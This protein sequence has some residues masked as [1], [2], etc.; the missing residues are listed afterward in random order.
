MW[1]LK[2]KLRHKDCTLAPLVEKYNVQIEFSPL[3]HYLEGKYV[4]TLAIHT[5]RGTD[6]AVKG[7]IK[8]LRKHPKI[9]RIEVSKAIFTLMKEKAS[10]GTYQTIYNPKLLY[11]T[12]G[13][14]SED[15][16]ET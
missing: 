6:K 16:Y 4:Y 1:Y 2:F 9:V 11:V 7:Y 14:N 8:E 10:F 13:Y 15:G 5:V 3:G 12:P